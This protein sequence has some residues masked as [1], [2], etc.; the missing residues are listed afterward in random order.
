MFSDFNEILK[1]ALG[2]CVTQLLLLDFWS[3]NVFM[4]VIQEKSLFKGYFEIIHREMLMDQKPNNKSC[5]T[6][7]P[8]STS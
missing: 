8:E 1:L 4:K 2:H 7:Y 6:H 5:L 3:I